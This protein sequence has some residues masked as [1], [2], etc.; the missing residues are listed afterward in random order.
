MSELKHYG[1]LGMRWGRRKGTSRSNEVEYRKKL[2]KITNNK[3]ANPNDIRRIKYRNQSAVKRVGKTMAV[4]AS[5]MII[6]DV[7]TGDIKK[8]GNMSK[9]DFIKR[10]TSIT[11]STAFEVIYNDAIAK[12]TANRYNNDG[13]IIN[14]KNTLITKE[15]C[16]DIFV[17][18]AIQMAPVAKFLISA[19]V[20]NTRINRARNEQIFK[21]WGGRILEEQFANI[22]TGV[23][24]TIT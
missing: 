9:Q 11:K 23:E 21:E 4:N 14:K 15:D 6:K 3:N 17:K 12:S 5:K 10:A 13:K 7:I 2:D 8:Y 24:Y 18:S 19:K 1:V 20:H 22:I 16:A